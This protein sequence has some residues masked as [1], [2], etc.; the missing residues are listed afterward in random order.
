M[1]NI[2]DVV[3]MHWEQTKAILQAFFCGGIA[4][5]IAFKYQR[6]G[7]TYHFFSSLCAFG[8]ASLFAQEWLSVVGGVLLHGVWPNASVY[9]TLIYGLLFLLV[10]RAKGNVSRMFNRGK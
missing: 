1:L 5:F 9:D 2:F 6:N 3:A 7:S 8:L 4:F 10:I